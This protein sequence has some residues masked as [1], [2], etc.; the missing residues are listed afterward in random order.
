MTLGINALTASFKHERLLL[1][2]IKGVPDCFQ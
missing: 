1:Q 2:Q